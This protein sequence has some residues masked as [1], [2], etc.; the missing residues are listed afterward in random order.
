MASTAIGSGYKQV[1]NYRIQVTDNNNNVCEVRMPSQ[2]IHAMLEGIVFGGMIHVTL[3]L[4][5]PNGQGNAGPI[6]TMVI[7]RDAVMP[8]AEPINDSKDIELEPLP[9]D[10]SLNGSLPHIRHVDL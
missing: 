3:P 4:Y 8:T 1:S 10:S 5:A 6:A 9:D 7:T 2:S